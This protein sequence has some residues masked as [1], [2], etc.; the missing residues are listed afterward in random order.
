MTDH[1]TLVLPLGQVTWSYPIS[2]GTESFMPYRADP[3]DTDPNAQWLVDVPRHVAKHLLHIGGFTVAETKVYVL[4]SLGPIRL[5]HRDGP[6]ACAW[7]GIKFE[8]EPDG[9]V[10]VPVEALAELQSHGFVVAPEPTRPDAPLPAKGGKSGRPAVPGAGP[11]ET[12]LPAG[13]SAAVQVMQATDTTGHVWTA[14]EEGTA[15][16]DGV[17]PAAAP[18]PAPDLPAAKKG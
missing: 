15:H 8:P 11:E 4:H 10:T 3:N 17:A 7:Q 18:A 2:H 14:D 12:I 13:L 6:A 1:V 16:P 5:I 9:A